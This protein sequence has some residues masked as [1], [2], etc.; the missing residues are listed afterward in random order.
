MKI[1]LWIAQI[2]L[3]IE[4]LHSGADK[5]LAHNPQLLYIFI[6]TC[7]V[8]GAVGLILPLVTG[9]LPFLTQWAAAGLA[10]IMILAAGFHISRNE[11]SHLPFVLALFAM[12]SFVVWGRGFRKSSRSE[13]TDV[14]R[15]S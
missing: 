8:A 4:F 5:L 15:S 13:S 7:E 1:A 2:L 12:A 6:G 11:Y 9:I 10:T 14:R 3:A